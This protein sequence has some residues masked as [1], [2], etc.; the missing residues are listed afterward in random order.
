VRIPPPKFCTDNGA[1][2][3]AAAGWRLALGQ[4]SG[5]DEDIF[6]TND[7]ERV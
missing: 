4:R 1:M 7:W 6:S 3:G 2:I 5:L